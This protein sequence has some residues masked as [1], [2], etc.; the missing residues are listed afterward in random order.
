MG[1]LGGTASG[2]CGHVRLLLPGQSAICHVRHLERLTLLLVDI[3][4]L[5]L[6][7]SHSRH[8]AHGISAITYPFCSFR[9]H[10]P[11]IFIADWAIAQGHPEEDSSFLLSIVGILNTVGVVRV[12]LLLLVA[13]FY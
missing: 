11:Y 8:S 4:I 2:L 1:L 5:P 3:P 6:C 12:V 7:P 9:Y 10:V 13:P